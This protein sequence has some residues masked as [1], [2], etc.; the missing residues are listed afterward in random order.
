M[1]LTICGGRT[2][3]AAIINL[4]VVVQSVISLEQQQQK[5]PEKKASLVCKEKQDLKDNKISPYF[6]YLDYYFFFAL[7]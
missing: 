1:L 2:H 5:T 7:L 6:K 4:T 3:Y